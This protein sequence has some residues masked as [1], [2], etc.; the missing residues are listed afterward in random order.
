MIWNRRNNQRLQGIAI[1]SEGDKS[2]GDTI[3]DA[4]LK[5]NNTIFMY[6]FGFTY[7]LNKRRFGFQVEHQ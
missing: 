4:P 3:N 2:F 7:V 1:I 6:T 5:T